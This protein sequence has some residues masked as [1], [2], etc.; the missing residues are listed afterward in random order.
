M[1]VTGNAP[2]FGSYL[3]GLVDVLG[4]REDL[5]ALKKSLSA[6]QARRPITKT[7]PYRKVKKVR[8]FLKEYEELAK[9]KGLPLGDT[10][11][12]LQQFAD[13][14]LFYCRISTG[15]RER[16]FLTLYVTLLTFA[17]LML[18]SFALEL[19]LRGAIEY[20]FAAEIGERDLYGPVFANAYD[21]ESNVAQYPPWLMGTNRN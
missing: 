2:Q 17:K 4:Q 19:A 8:D 7:E 3:V 6:S 18:S 11:P 1:D 13:T 10:R 12:K 21:F 14:V 16:F 20:G 9:E 5:A 15:D